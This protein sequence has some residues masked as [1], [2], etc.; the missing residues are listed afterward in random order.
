MP[1]NDSI[2]SIA[3]PKPQISPSHAF[4]ALKLLSDSVTTRTEQLQPLFS[5]PKFHSDD[6][7]DNNSSILNFIIE[8]GVPRAVIS[9]TNS[10]HREFLQTWHNIATYISENWAVGRILRIQYKPKPKSVLLIAL[11]TL[12]HG[13]PG[14]WIF[15]VKVL[16]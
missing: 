4:A 2:D 6:D 8:Q 14:H 5:T 3:V 15:W 11:A 10:I 9:V 13:G 12:K 7:V 1:I 16:N